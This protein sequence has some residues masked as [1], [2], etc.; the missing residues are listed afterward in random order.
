MENAVIFIAYAFFVKVKV[1]L[2][3]V[4]L[5]TMKVYAIFV[6][7]ESFVLDDKLSPA[8]KI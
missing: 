7:C 6:P 3:P 1:A 4:K 2:S 5:S 8:S